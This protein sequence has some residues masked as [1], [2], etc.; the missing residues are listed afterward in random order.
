MGLPLRL[1][2]SLILLTTPHGAAGN[3]INQYVELLKDVARLLGEGGADQIPAHARSAPKDSKRIQSLISSLMGGLRTFGTL[4]QQ[5][6]ASFLTKTALDSKHFSA[7]L[8]NISLYLQSTNPQDPAAESF[9]LNSVDSEEVENVS[10]PRATLDLRDLFVSLRA[11]RD[12]DSLVEL[13][14]S[15][16]D[17]LTDH[18][19]LGWIFQKENW[20]VLVELIETFS[21]D[22]FSG[23]FAQAKASIQELLCSLTGHSDCSINVD[24]LE[25]LGQLLDWKNWKTVVNLQ[26]NGPPPRN[27]RF[28]PWIDLQE[29]GSDGDGAGN[30]NAVQSLLRILSR[31]SS[32]R[33]GSEGTATANR[34]RTTWGEDAMWSGLQE[35]RQSIL[36]KVGTS[37]YTNFKRKVSRMTGSLVNKASSVIGIPRS[38][39]NGKCSAGNLRQLLLWGVMNNVSWDA[40]RLGFGPSERPLL[41][42]RREDGSLAPPR[43][44]RRASWAP[45]ELAAG[46][47]QVQEEEDGSPSVED[48]CNDSAP[49]LPGVSNFTVY[50]YCNLSNRSDGPGRPPPDLHSACT[51]AAWYLSAAHEDM[52][53]AQ[54]CMR[55]YP[56]QFASK[57]CGPG[58]REWLLPLC[59]G[60]Q[61]I[62]PN[63]GS[64][65]APCTELPV[66]HL[67]YPRHCLPSALR[68][69][70][71]NQTLLARHSLVVD[72]CRGGAGAAG[73]PMGTEALHQLCSRLDLMDVN[74]TWL[75]H[76]CGA[77]RREGQGGLVAGD[78]ERLL[79]MW[80]SLGNADQ[81]I[82]WYVQRLCSNS[83]TEEGAWLAVLCAW[84]PP[85]LES[86][87]PRGCPR[88]L[89]M[90]NGHLQRCIL[91]NLTGQLLGLCT[92]RSWSWAAP[93]CSQLRQASRAMGVD[94]PP[95]GLG[96][97]GCNYTSWSLDM[98]LDGELLESCRDQDAQGLKETVCPN[99]TLYH[100]F[101]RHHPWAVGD[102]PPLECLASRLLDLI[103]APPTVDTG[104]L[105]ADPAGFLKDLLDQFSRCDDQDSGW[106]SGANY[107]VQVFHHLLGPPASW[108]HA[109][110]EVRATLSE[111]L[112]LSSLLDNSSSWNT[113]NT[114]TTVSIL[115]TVETFLR[116]ENN[117]ALKKDLLNCFSPVIWDLLQNQH[118]SPVLRVI[119]QEYLLMPQENFRK[120]LMSAESEA[121]K[122]L[123]SHMHR[124]WWQLQVGIDQVCNGDLRERL[125]GLVCFSGQEDLRLLLAAWPHAEPVSRALLGCIEDGTID[126]GSTVAQL[127]ATHLRG[128]NASTL[129][130]RDLVAVGGILP[131]LGVSFLQNLSAQQR[132]T[133]LSGLGSASVSAAQAD[134]LVT[135]LTKEVNVT[136]DVLCHLG[137]L[138]PGV[139]VSALRLLP[140]PVLAGACSCFRPFLAHLSSAHKAVLLEA[141]RSVERDAGRRFGL[142]GCLVPFVPL[143]DLA[144]DPETFLRNRS[145]FGEWRWSLQQAQFIFKR[146]QEVSNITNNSLLSLGNVARGADCDAVRRQTSDSEFLARVGFL[147]GLHGG[148]GQPLRKC[149]VKELSAR[150]G[151][152]RIDILRMGPEVVADL[153]LRILTAL[154]NDSMRAVLDHLARHSVH[155][156][157][158]PPH[159]RS[160]LAER[161]LQLLGVGAEDE[162]SGEVLDSLGPLVTFMEE[163]KVKQINQPDLL[164]RLDEVKGYCIP[165]QNRRSFGW[166]LTKAGVLG[167]VSGWNLPQMEFVDRLALTLRPE[168]IHRLPQEVL[169]PDTVELVV[170]G[171]G[172]WGRGEVGRLCR[173]QESRSE[174][175]SLLSKKRSLAVNAV[176]SIVKRR[177]D[178][179]PDCIDI[180]ATFPAAW[181]SSQLA[182]MANDQ[183]A[184]CLETLG[185]DQ[186]LSVEQLKIL[187]SKAKQLYGPISSMKRWQLLQLGRAASQ[188]TDRDLQ[189]LDQSDL[190]LL[191]FLGQIDEW[192]A[193]QRKAV[194]G[195]WQGTHLDVTTLVALGHLICGMSVL[196][197]GRIYPE[198]FSKAVL[199]IGNLELRCSESQLE[200]LAKLAIHPQAFGPVNKW[201]A[202][203]FTE[204]G[205]VAAGLSDMA[206]SSLVEEQIEG[207]TPTAISLIPP[208]KFAVVF[209]ADQLS[210]FAG[211]QASAVTSGQYRRLSTEQRAAV[212]AAQYDGALHQEPRGKNASPVPASFNLAVLNL[213]LSVTCFLGAR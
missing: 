25:H 185:S 22:L 47:V 200:A 131:V 33:G 150:P 108:S 140:P 154:P 87:P 175:T 189:S 111:A 145:L 54:V 58:S 168:D 170:R 69:I 129:A 114:N 20:E 53:W 143:K 99:A 32:R 8:Y 121:V 112:L 197:M 157:T 126:A 91:G 120:L 190:S 67:D 76:L 160:Y 102:C 137:R 152:F 40:P 36:H 192:S 207:L 92:E 195:R 159:K 48:V 94:V 30:V 71:S 12:L 11:S 180:K 142:L 49:G 28:R 4:P 123:L 183:L 89:D 35:L 26:P 15:I 81:C 77:G 167:D 187:V 186:D 136:V 88:L 144:F 29:S 173:G 134:Q 164:L 66:H 117:S 146:L 113:S 208:S 75:D 124:N 139:G 97:L 51:H 125:G 24:W 9:T 163:G 201:G 73:G 205:S 100:W 174:R 206:L 199:F 79:E 118:D 82:S 110:Q 147:G 204:I 202:E 213:S 84:L 3:G 191:S 165:E 86:L 27:E 141:L 13:L 115:Q 46:E 52:Y 104:Q 50:L 85:A 64:S 2:L 107:I 184:D 148:I 194:F 37:V 55:F 169:T 95:H 59:S 16:M 153:P 74:R 60:L 151:T 188:L 116:E 161:A 103:P 149:I 70:C 19:L 209:S 158:L 23:T 203:I 128:R 155:L 181:S 43:E 211:A 5:N 56:A 41:S 96:P 127:L 44:G 63:P 17:L 133:V 193:K 156:L 130:P 61:T 106:I 65:A 135:Q 34:S 90:S 119:F 68:P 177:P 182:G 72:L 7:F 109:E 122:R 18:Q 93:F 196:E 98:F 212:T 83:S 31:P 138:L 21:Q 14:Q 172:R 198:E 210:Y 57:A 162:V 62:S 45:E 80:T 178:G 105:C 101:S 166:M 39:Q 171:E 132:L 6:V 179:S 176:K 42:C 38:D 78:C 10:P 1:V